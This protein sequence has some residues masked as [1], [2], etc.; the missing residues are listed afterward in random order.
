VKAKYIYEAFERRSAEDARADLLFPKLREIK[1]NLSQ[2]QIIDQLWEEELEIKKLLKIS[3][4]AGV[5]EKSIEFLQ[6]IFNKLMEDFGS[7]NDIKEIVEESGYFDYLGL[8]ADFNVMLSNNIGV[9]EEDFPE[10]DLDLYVFILENYKWWRSDKF[11]DIK[12]DD[13]ELYFKREDYAR[14]FTSYVYSNNEMMKQSI[15]VSSSFE[16]PHYIEEQTMWLSDTILNA[17]DFLR[18]LA[19]DGAGFDGPWKVFKKLD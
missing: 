17:K 11:S 10:D 18:M 15:S 1:K 4:D 19:D 6:N 9:P 2:I 3:E 14:R 8:K 13:G 12:I 16:S 5:I 7:Y